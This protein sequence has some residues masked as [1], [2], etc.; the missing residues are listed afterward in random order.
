MTTRTV[1]QPEV[2]GTAGHL[3]AELEP[4]F[5][6]GKVDLVLSG[7]LHLWERTHP[8]ADGGGRVVRRDES[9]SGGPEGDVY[10]DPA[11]PVHLTVRCRLRENRCKDTEIHTAQDE[12]ER[13]IK[14]RRAR[15]EDRESGR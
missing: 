7:H 6:A 13:S 5:I 2:P 9:R 4:L 15:R 10:V 12:T 11:A 14:R 1:A 3:T 8:V